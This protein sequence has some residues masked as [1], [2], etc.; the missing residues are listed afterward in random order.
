MAWMFGSITI[1]EILP[2]VRIVASDVAIFWKRRTG[3][4]M[5]AASVMNDRSKT[6]RS[7]RLEEMS[8]YRWT[9]V[10]KMVQRCHAA[11]WMLWSSPTTYSVLYDIFPILRRIFYDVI[12]HDWNINGF[13]V[14]LRRHYSKIF[15]LMLMRRVFGDVAIDVFW[16]STRL[17]FLKEYFLDD[18]TI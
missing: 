1:K 14:Q 11:F 7:S 10:L 12:F 18:G 13:K 15:W 4:F 6:W 16:E 9:L 5:M 2:M 8:F 17:P 3:L